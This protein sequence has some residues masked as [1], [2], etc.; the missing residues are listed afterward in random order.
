MAN[1][2]AIT[3]S[4]DQ[5]RSPQPGNG[6]KPDRSRLSASLSSFYAPIFS[7]TF[8]LLMLLGRTR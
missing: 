5:I 8:L 1:L 6:S 4:L 2:R 3:F 7:N